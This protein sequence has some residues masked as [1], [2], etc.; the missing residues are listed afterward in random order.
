METDANGVCS[1][2]LRDILENW[3]VGKP[4]PKVFYTVPV[5]PDYSDC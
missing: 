2:S 1:H 3:P 5:S 4:K